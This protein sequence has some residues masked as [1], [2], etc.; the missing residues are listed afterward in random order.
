MDS[1]NASKVAK[2]YREQ[3]AKMALLIFYPFR[4]LI[5]LKM[6]G[7]YWAK[8]SSK[9]RRWTIEQETRLWQ[10][11]FNILQNIQVIKTLEKK[12]KRARDPNTVQNLL[13]DKEKV[14]DSGTSSRTHDDNDTPDI[15]E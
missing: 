15:T 5:D 2:Y 8:F 10:E 3:Y 1:G 7:S 4:K 6:R 12:I 9:R 13:K 14:E 11:G